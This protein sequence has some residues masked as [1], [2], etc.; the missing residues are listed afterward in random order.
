MTEGRNGSC[1]ATLRQ[2]MPCPTFFDVPLGKGET[3]DAR[4]LGLI[5]E[6]EHVCGREF[7]G[8]SREDASAFIDEHIDYLHDLRGRG[9]LSRDDIPEMRRPR[10]SEEGEN[11]EPSKR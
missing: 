10:A 8:E 1:K 9:I 6:I 2:G 7:A 5:R 3:P 11:G 4:Q